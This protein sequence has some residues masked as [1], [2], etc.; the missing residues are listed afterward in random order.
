[1]GCGVGVMPQ[2][3]ARF[4]GA[5]WLRQAL[6]LLADVGVDFGV[7]D[8]KR[9]IAMRRVGGRVDFFFWVGVPPP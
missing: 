5:G 1:M 8:G 9:R 2:G 4:W 6:T 3:A 7:Q